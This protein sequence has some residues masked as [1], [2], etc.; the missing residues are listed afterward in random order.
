MV[1][2]SPSSSKLSFSPNPFSPDFDGRD[3]FTLI[4]YVLTLPV[5]AISVRVYDVCGRLIRVLENNSP[6]GAKGEMVWD[7]R[8]DDRRRARIGMY[9]VVLEAIDPVGGAMESVRGVVVLAAR[10]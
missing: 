3:D 8:D 6:A 7:G 1:L 4:Q 2:T 9:L 10:L 5:S